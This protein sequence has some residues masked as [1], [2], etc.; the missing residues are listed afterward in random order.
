MQSETGDRAACLQR[1]LDQRPG[2][3][4]RLMVGGWAMSNMS[5]LDFLWS[6]APVFPLDSTG[7]ALAARL[8]EAA[9]QVGY[10]LAL[11]TKEGVGEAEIGSGAGARVREQ[12]FAQTQA[13]FE[14][15]LDRISRGQ[16]E[17][18]PSE[19]LGTCR[20]VALALFD[21]EVLPGLADRSET[22]RQ[23]AVQAR[24]SLLGAFKGQAGMGK[25]IYTA[26]QL[27]RPKHGKKQEAVT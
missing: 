19:W 4:F 14:A 2:E 23:A 6:E 7:E 12:F 13:A 17:A 18:I 21:A 5:P 9:E 15:A 11:N 25:K 3:T 22:R 20:R 8:V 16:V 1:F 24:R 26:L 27:E 10:T